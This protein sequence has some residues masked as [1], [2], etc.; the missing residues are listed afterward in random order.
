MTL[1]QR[2]E[3]N[4][5]HPYFLEMRLQWDQSLA[6]Y[7]T[8]FEPRCPSTEEWIKKM[9]Y[10]CTMEYYSAIFYQMDTKEIGCVYNTNLYKKI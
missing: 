5:S 10:I 1:F 3:E 6:K 9:W 8:V 4:E 7:V 2:R